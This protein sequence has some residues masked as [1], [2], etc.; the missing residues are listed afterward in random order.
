MTCVWT[1]AFAAALLLM[2]SWAFAQTSPAS[3]PASAPASQPAGGK[4]VFEDSFKDLS[5]WTAEG[6]HTVEVKDGSLHVVTVDDKRQVGQFV[7]CKQE[8]PDDFRVEFDVT[9]GSKSGFFL[10]FF[11]VR[12]V[13]GEDI[14]GKGLFDDYLPWKSWNPY[15]DWDKYTS[16]ADRKDHSSR[17]RGYHVSYRRNE[18]A[19]CNLRKNPGL[20]LKRSSTVDALLPKDQAAHV[21]LTKQAGH[22]M[23]SVDGKAFMDWTDDDKP[24]RGGR[25]GFRNV[26]DSDA[27]YANVKIY[28]LARR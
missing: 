25:F 7:W 13:K 26:Y 27:S 16:P 22:V 11:C 20:V 1:V 18:A 6:P 15:A 5:N 9:P 24:Y 28:D 17:I 10:V 3:Q 8:L 2:T 4:L 21:V 12:G 23:L 19:N 14:L